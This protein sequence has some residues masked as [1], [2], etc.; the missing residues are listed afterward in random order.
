M[1]KIYSIVMH[2]S[3]KNRDTG[4]PFDPDHNDR[5]IK[6]LPAHIDPART[7]DNEYY[8][9]LDDLTGFEK[10]PEGKTFKQYELEFYMKHF[11]DV[12]S[13]RKKPRKIEDYYGSV[14]TAPEETILQIGKQGDLDLVKDKRPFVNA[15][16][17]YICAHQQLWPNI[18]FLDVA[19]HAD[20]A[21]LHAHVR[22]V[23]IFTHPDGTEEALQEKCLE[24]AG[25]PLPDP[26][27][28]GGRYNSRKGTYRERARALWVESCRK[29]GYPS[30]D[31]EPGGRA[32]LTCEE[33]RLKM[34]TQRVKQER[35]KLDR[36]EAETKE[37]L[38]K[39][40]KLREEAA[41]AE[42]EAQN[43]YIR[44]KKDH[45][46]DKMRRFISRLTINGKPGLQ[47][48]EEWLE[49]DRQK[50]KARNKENFGRE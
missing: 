37:R 44:S 32:H 35:E 25:I 2:A 24:Q 14:R 40:E 6:K 45:M 27:M 16:Y 7:K 4:K 15:V 10:K 34:D 26:T 19:I 46:A 48:F 5:Q 36:L 38:L 23:Y 8:F 22:Q 20:E 30:L 39:A 43:V 41:R 33:Y 49:Q 17:N 28:E 11:S 18:V 50:K 21:C 47:A 1:K 29:M 13:K 42:A 12:L 9:V 31:K 3:R